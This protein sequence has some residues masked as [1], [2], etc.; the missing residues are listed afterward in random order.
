MVKRVVKQKHFFHFSTSHQ[1]HHKDDD[2]QMFSFKGGYVLILF[3]INIVTLLVI[4]SKN[5]FGWR[6]RSGGDG[7]E[8]K[9]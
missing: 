2:K 7:G 5:V 9:P 4:G 1:K 8:D 3:N 6:R